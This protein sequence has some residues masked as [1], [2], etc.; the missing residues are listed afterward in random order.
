M[1]IIGTFTKNSDGFTGTI[2]TLTLNAKVTIKPCAKDTDKAPD[3]R[4]F[5]GTVE[6]GAGW[7]K[8]SAAGSDYMSCKFDDPSFPAPIYASLVADDNGE[9]HSLIWSR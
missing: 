6:L 2:K 8:K 7:S 9:A 3:H 5:C 4:I 1:A